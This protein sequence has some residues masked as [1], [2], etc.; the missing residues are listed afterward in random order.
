MT[1]VFERVLA[2]SWEGLAREQVRIP[3]FLAISSSVPRAC[4]N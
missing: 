1:A 3:L 2:R 4:S